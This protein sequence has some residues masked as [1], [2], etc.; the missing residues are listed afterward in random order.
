MFAHRAVPLT[1]G[2]YTKVRCVLS[3]PIF[4]NLGAA[5]MNPQFETWSQHDR[6]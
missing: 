3:S 2:K 4:S 6:E 1:M 5:Q